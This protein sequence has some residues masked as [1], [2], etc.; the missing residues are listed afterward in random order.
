MKSSSVM[1]PCVRRITDRLLLY[2]RIM[3]FTANP[4]SHAGRGLAHI[5]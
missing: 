1:Q 3:L 4:E 2:R 5:F